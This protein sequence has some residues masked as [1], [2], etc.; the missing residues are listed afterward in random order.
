MILLMLHRLLLKKCVGSHLEVQNIGFV[1]TLQM[2]CQ[3]ALVV[4]SHGLF[5]KI[6]QQLEISGLECRAEMILL[7]SLVMSHGQRG[8]FHMVH[9]EVVSEAVEVP[10]RGMIVEVVGEEDIVEVG[11]LGMLT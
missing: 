5:Q 10:Y 7:M 6:W 9:H 3:V 8:S 1:Q 2:Y 4:S 11:T